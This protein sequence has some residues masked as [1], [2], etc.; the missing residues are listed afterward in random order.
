[1]WKGRVWTERSALRLLRRRLQGVAAAKHQ[2]DEEER[3][4]PP[5]PP[6]PSPPPPSSGRRCMG[7]VLGPLPWILRKS[8]VQVEAAA[9]TGRPQRPI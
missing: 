1:M 9:T 5:P 8:K 6:P 7:G 2:A 3:G 4:A